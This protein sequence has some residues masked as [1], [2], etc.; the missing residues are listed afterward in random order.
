MAETVDA[1]HGIPDVLINENSPDVKSIEINIQIIKGFFINTISLYEAVIKKACD[2]CQ[3]IKSEEF[4]HLHK[5]LCEFENIFGLFEVNFDKN[6][7]NNLVIIKDRSK[8]KASKRSLD[9]EDNEEE[10]EEEE[11]DKLLKGSPV[12]RTRSSSSR[13]PCL[14]SSCDMTYTTEDAVRIHFIKNH[15]KRGTAFDP[16]TEEQEAPFDSTLLKSDSSG[17]YS[18]DDTACE[19]VTQDRSNFR[20]HLKRH[21]G[22]K[23]YKCHKCSKSFFTRDPLIIHFVR[24]H[25]KEVDWS[26]ASKDVRKLRKTLRRL[27]MKEYKDLESDDELENSDSDMHGAVGEYDEVLS[28]FVSQAIYSAP[29]VTKTS[30]CS[31]DSTALPALSE[32]VDQE[33]VL[34]A[35]EPAV[36]MT[37]GENECLEIKN[38]FKEQQD[39]ENQVDEPQPENSFNIT[40]SMKD[41]DFFGDSMR[42][43]REGASDEIGDLIAQTQHS[44]SQ[45]MANMSLT[46]TKNKV[47]EPK[48][49]QRARKF[50]CP[51]EYCGQ[52][53]FT[54][55][56]L[57]IHLKASHD[58]SNPYPC[59]EEDCFSRFKKPALLAQHRKRHQ[60]QYTCTVCPYKTH[61][62]ALM[63]R[64]NRQ[65]AGQPLHHQ[66]EYCGDAF[67]FLGSLSNHLRK[68]HKEVEPLKCTWDGCDK[69]FKSMIG[70]NKHRRE[71]HMKMRAEMPCEWPEC[72]ASFSNRSSLN[73]HMRIHTNERPFQCDWQDCGKW[74]RLRETLKRHIKLHQGYKPYPC[75]FN[76]CDRAFYAK[77][78]MKTHVERVHCLDRSVLEGGDSQLVELTNVED[79][80]EEQDVEAAEREIAE[81]D[82]HGLVNPGELLVESI[83]VDESSVNHVIVK[84]E[85]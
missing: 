34:M 42:L 76:N 8:K 24:C 51:E 17:K 78:A 3:T 75:P 23:L 50:K 84:L 61:L 66:C 20:V 55:K 6:M 60:V 40:V 38:E 85:E 10:E 28:G 30:T 1:E 64:H 2:Q 45:F 83:E 65:H 77:R 19:Y 21:K 56:N 11:A 53:F 25:T 70:L 47:I 35:V 69:R 82:D 5:N 79:V 68:V 16:Y 58:K 41:A 73:N 54:K 74:F 80:A 67:E 71:F 49:K 4:I 26:L 57:V 31:D 29:N 52:D 12:R 22:A 27:T 9:V 81:E 62:A 46:D 14:L 18:C 59:P 13:F 63:A 44:D 43:I 37:E 72:L 7:F 15:C 39:V 48:I 36:S 32:P 33:N